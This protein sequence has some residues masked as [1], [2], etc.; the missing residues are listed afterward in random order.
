MWVSYIDKNR[1]QFTAWTKMFKIS[2]LHFCFIFIF[3]NWRVF[4]V[5]YN[6]QT[7]LRFS[8]YFILKSL[9]ERDAY[10]KNAQTQSNNQEVI[11]TSCIYMCVIFY[12]NLELYTDT[13][14]KSES[15]Q[16]R[17]MQKWSDVYPVHV[18]ASFILC[19]LWKEFIYAVE[20]SLCK[21]KYSTR[22][23]KYNISFINTKSV[24]IK[25]K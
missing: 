7:K 14:K 17:T 4:L 12:I 18:F 8:F 25:T 15:L 24:K 9:S 21:W 6:R 2:L 16:T 20:R 11:L 22:E 5:C 13:D 23:W 19:V 10:P 1:N 3:V